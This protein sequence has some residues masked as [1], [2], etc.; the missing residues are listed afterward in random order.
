MPSSLSRLAEAPREQEQP[1]LLEA[2]LPYRIS[3]LATE[4]S[5]GLAQIYGDRFGIS[6]P[7][8]RVMATLG[9]FT[10]LTAR[11]IGEHAR[12]HKTTVSRAVAALEKRRLLARR[13][14]RADMREAHLILTEAG[15]A[16]YGD[17]VP[18]AQRFEEVLCAGLSLEDR[19][20]LH[21]LMQRLSAG[22]ARTGGETH[23]Q[24]ER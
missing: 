8:W 14:N 4:I 7:E 20:R 1:L 3:V 22:V 23:P 2:F 10:M 12:M 15:R 9:Q 18:L 5:Q 19:A 6:T 13:I 16:I 17:I 21:D 11:D 24:G